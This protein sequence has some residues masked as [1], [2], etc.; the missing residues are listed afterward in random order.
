LPILPA[1]CAPFAELV[2][3]SKASVAEEYYAERSGNRSVGD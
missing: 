1:E 3:L 2:F